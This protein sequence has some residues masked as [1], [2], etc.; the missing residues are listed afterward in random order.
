M[1]AAPQWNKRTGKSWTQN[2]VGCVCIVIIISL[3][4]CGEPGWSQDYDKVEMACVLSLWGPGFAIFFWGQEDER[5]M[6]EKTGD[7][8][9]KFWLWVCVTRRWKWKEWLVRKRKVLREWE[10]QCGIL[11]QRRKIYLSQNKHKALSSSWYPDTCGA[12]IPKVRCWLLY[13][14]S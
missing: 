5:R 3:E 6:L 12:V 9:V 7:M 1:S 8:E 2:S 11:I 13:F 10:W 14:H 4:H